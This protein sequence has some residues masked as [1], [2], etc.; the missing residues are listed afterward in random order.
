MLEWMDDGH[1]TFLGY[2]EY[3]ILAEG[4]E[5]VLRAVSGSGLGIL[6]ATD[7]RPIS[8]SFAQLPPEVRRL[9]REKT[10]LSLTKANSRATVHRP[11]YLDYVG[12]KRFDDSGEVSGERRFLGLYTHTAY[13]ASP[14]EIP[15][16]RRKAQRVV[17]R[18]GLLLGSHD[19]K[20]LLD[21]LETYPRDELFQ[22]SED[23]LLETALGILHLG[24]RR[25]VRLFVRRDAFERFVSCLVYL[26]RERFDTENRQ[27]IQDILQE[28]FGG[29]SVDYTT[30]VSESVLARLHV[31]VYTKQ[32]AIP[33]YDVGE[34]EA[35]LAAATRAWTDDL[36]DALL[37]Q[38]GE[39]RAGP[40]FERYGEAFPGAYREDF[41][42]RQ[43]VLD[44]ERIERLDPDGDLGM[45]LYVPL[46]V[47]AR[48]PRVQAASL[49]AAA[50]PLRRAAAARE[51][52][53]QGQRRAA[54]RDQ[55]RQAARR[56]G[57]TTSGSATT[58]EPSSRRTTSGRRSRTRSHAPGAGR[59]RTTASTVS[60]SRR[61]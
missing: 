46:D 15:V 23:E 5:D 37:E 54:V 10:P 29:T 26:P 6:R 43:A 13:S 36:R 11:A 40:L 42:A 59:R 44:I 22:I 33:E 60:S 18:S 57:S 4:G 58:K 8:V 19:H 39:E 20:S 27:Q 14:W 38:L 45:S 24:E 47:D 1:F 61:G 3:E 9:A 30:R 12:V 32:G 56:S 17:E 16:L 53:R 50:P 52:G 7:D 51:H 35:R 25:H 34:I 2:R 48:P 28:A 31:V 55:A 21:I 49:R 41:S